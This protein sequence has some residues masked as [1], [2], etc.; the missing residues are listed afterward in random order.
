MDGTVAVFLGDLGVLGEKLF[1]SAWD[2]RGPP[3]F[4]GVLVSSKL[5]SKG[6]TFADRD[7]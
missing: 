2:R 1:L 4:D 6:A 5:D 3:G 7:F